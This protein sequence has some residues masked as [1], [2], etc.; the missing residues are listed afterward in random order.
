MTTASDW[1]NGYIRAWE[2]QS[3]DDVRALFTDDAEYWLR[4][5]DDDPVIGIDAILEMWREPEP[6]EPVH[7]L[8]V[9]IEDDRLGIITGTVDYPGH[10]T[11]SNMWEV[12]FAPDGRAKKFVEWFMTPRKND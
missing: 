8:A 5:D 2:S 4:P 10:E 12:W 6:S 9:L 1:L 7:D 11:Y 3:D